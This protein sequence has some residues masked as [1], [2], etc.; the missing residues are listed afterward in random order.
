MS[1]ALDTGVVNALKNDAT[2]QA[3]VPGGVYRDVAPESVVNSALL[4][5][6]QVY[7]LVVLQSALSTYA[8]NTLAFETC[9]Y[10]VKFISPS[11]S[12]LGAQ[13][14]I[15]RAEVVLAGVYGSAVG[16][17]AIT[18]SRRAER[19]SYTD[20]DGP[21]YWQHRGVSWMLLASPTP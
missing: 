16:G 15:D 14:A 2:L 10:L 18:A 13:A 4:D 19:I 9:Y 8:F 12:P 7:G 6:S 5:A 1:A 21:I 17:F 3:L 20:P 11:T